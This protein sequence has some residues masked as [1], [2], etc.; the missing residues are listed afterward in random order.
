MSDNPLPNDKLAELVRKLG[1]DIRAPLGSIISTSEMLG[2]GFYDAL[3][4]KQVRA[5]DRIQR[6]SQRVL[7]MLDDFV[8]YVKAQEGQLDLNPKSFE[9]RV[10]ISDWG[11]QVESTAEKKGLALHLTSTENVPETLTGDYPVIGRALMPLLWN[12]VSFTS[13]GD[14]WVESDWVDQTWLIKVRDTGPGIA[15]ENIPHIFEAFWRGE[16]RPQV[17]TAGA[18]LGLAVAQA[19]AKSLGARLTLEH[20]DKTGSTFLLALPFLPTE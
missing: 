16:E 4:P 8:L 19:V 14:V 10:C 2:Q 1:H 6:N 7:A 11:K 18:G 5:N 9:P 3:T 17:A 12:A 15:A 13:T 20:T